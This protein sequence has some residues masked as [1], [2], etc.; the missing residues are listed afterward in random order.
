MSTATS[1]PQL[2]PELILTHHLTL[3]STGVL[4]VLSGISAALASMYR[5]LTVP[6]DDN[7]VIMMIL[8]FLAVVPSLISCIPLMTTNQNPR[9]FRGRATWFAVAAVV[10]TIQCFWTL[11]SHFEVEEF[12][13]FIFPIMVGCWCSFATLMAVR[14]NPSERARLI[15]RVVVA[16]V[17]GVPVLL[18]ITAMSTG[19]LM[20]WWPAIP[21][22]V[23]WVIVLAGVV[24]RRMGAVLVLFVLSMGTLLS[25]LLVP[26]DLFAPQWLIGSTA[27]TLSTCTGVLI[28]TNP[29]K[30]VLAGEKTEH[31]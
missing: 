27:L 15:S 18:V 12:L 1:K 13:L 8:P 7:A 21:V 29:Q 14:A 20:F 3:A 31:Q 28:H 16:V 10:A 19:T 4:S 17:L 2:A 5:D 26:S 25:A 6:L 30:D 11:F 23:L 22:M 24:A 9:G